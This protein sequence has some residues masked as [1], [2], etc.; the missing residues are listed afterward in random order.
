MTFVLPLPGRD[1]SISPASPSYSLDNLDNL[2]DH[3]N[4]NYQVQQSLE[5]DEELGYGVYQ[6]VDLNYVVVATLNTSWGDLLNL[7]HLDDHLKWSTCSWK[8]SEEQWVLMRKHIARQLA[9]II[10]GATGAP[11][12]A[13]RVRYTIRRKQSKGAKVYRVYLY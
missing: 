3:I 8:P 4:S 2:I 12:D 13:S 5:I 10:Q 11:I 9:S 7:P 1:G 6:T